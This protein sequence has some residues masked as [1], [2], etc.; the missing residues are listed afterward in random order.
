LHRRGK[1][2]SYFISSLVAAAAF[3]FAVAAVPVEIV[4]T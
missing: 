4:A 3:A 2:K 1:S